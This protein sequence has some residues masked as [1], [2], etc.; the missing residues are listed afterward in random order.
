MA[1][2]DQ[3]QY[4]RRTLRALLSI[5]E[6]PPDTPCQEG[7]APDFMV[8]INSQAIGIE[9]TRYQSGQVVGA[10]GIERRSVEAEWEKFIRFSKRFCEE[11]SELKD[12]SIIFRFKDVV[13]PAR[14]R[15]LFLTEIFNFVRLHRD[16]VGF[17]YAI[18]SVHQ[19]TS[20]LMLKY[21]TDICLCSSETAHLDSNL[22][23]GK[24]SPFGDNLAQIVEKK[25]ALHYRPASELW[26]VIQCSGLI[27]E[28]VLPINGASEF[29][30]SIN[31]QTKLRAGRFSKAYISTAMGWFCW[32]RPTE[33]R[34]M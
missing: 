27:T 9:M 24:L 34:R 11:Q 19:F 5:L 33:W 8:Q 17:Q 3:K 13:P 31:L 7:E 16:A 1:R 21:L 6:V 20:Q 10:A 32:E 15:Q 12:V 29:N 22:M 23:A 28:T 25:S 14:E 2:L 4:E 26:L 30:R 18:F